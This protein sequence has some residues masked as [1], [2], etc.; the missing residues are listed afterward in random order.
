MQEQLFF[1]KSGTLYE[2]AGYHYYRSGRD[3]FLQDRVMDYTID[4]CAIQRKIA[5]AIDFYSSEFSLGDLDD[6]LLRSF[7]LEPSDC[8]EVLSRVDFRLVVVLKKT[9]AATSIFCKTEKDPFL[10]IRKYLLAG[11]I[12]HRLRSN[13]NS[14]VDFCTKMD[15]K[16][17]PITVESIGL[18]ATKPGSVQRPAPKEKKKSALKSVKDA[19]EAKERNELRPIVFEDEYD[20]ELRAL[21]QSICM[22]AKKNG[23]FVEVMYGDQ[24]LMIPRTPFI[25][26]ATKRQRKDVDITWSRLSPFDLKVDNDCQF[27]SDWWIGAGLP[28]YAYKLAEKGFM[29][30]ALDE[31]LFQASCQIA[32]VVGDVIMNKYHLGGTPSSEQEMR[33][34]AGSYITKGLA[35]HLPIASII[36][37]L[38]SKG[39]KVK[40]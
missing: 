24:R 36:N 27:H 38:E 21:R 15:D 35:H 40:T 3:V 18:F 23:G 19:Y 16:R 28:I 29:Y 6:L 32:P 37:V 39:F 10:F 22:Q 31:V 2:V 5:K 34:I 20:N 7:G 12:I 8:F 11:G 9:K 4:G 1:S 25:L 26:W 33:M 30:H 13:V 14:V 17:K